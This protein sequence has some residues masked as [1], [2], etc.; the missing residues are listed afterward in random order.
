MVK[1]VLFI[2]TEAT[3]LPT[4]K[5]LE[6]TSHLTLQTR[7]DSGVIFLR[8]RAPLPATLNAEIS[9]PIKPFL[10]TTVDCPT[11]NRL[12]RSAHFP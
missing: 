2:S 3:T 4:L 5:D 7:Y 8:T 10:S 9:M 11:F 6:P 12:N 1:Q